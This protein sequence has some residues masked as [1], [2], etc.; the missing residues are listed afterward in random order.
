MAGAGDGKIE[1]MAPAAGA[2][3]WPRLQERSAAGPA[4]VR[5]RDRASAA[6]ARMIESEVAERR[7]F[8]WLPVFFGV[9]VLV[10]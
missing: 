5:L 6:I 3:G 7:L 9:G 1:G 10:Y 4:S 2:F 8:L